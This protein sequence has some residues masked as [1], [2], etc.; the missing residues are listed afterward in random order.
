M[1][2]DLFRGI[3]TA[4]LFFLFIGLWAWTWSK[5][6]HTEFESAAQLPLEDGLSPPENNSKEQ[7]Q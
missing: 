6:R 7:E 3:L 1:D 5:K 4:V 2:I